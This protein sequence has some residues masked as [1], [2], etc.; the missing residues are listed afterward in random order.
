VFLQN[1]RASA[2]FWII[3]IIFPKKKREPGLQFHEPSP[4]G[5]STSP[6]FI[7]WW[8]SITGLVVQIKLVKGYALILISCVGSQ[9]NGHELIR[10]GGGT[11]VVVGAGSR[12]CAMATHWRWVARWLRCSIHYGVSSYGFRMTRGTHFTNLRQRK[13]AIPSGR[14]QRSSLWLGRH[15]GAPPVNLRLQERDEKLAGIHPSLL[16]RFNSSKWWQKLSLMAT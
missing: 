6:E 9:M 7:K 16:C 8:S 13:W 4:R 5:R 1:C 10:W 12:R 3:W 11:L 15:W 2:I 14:R